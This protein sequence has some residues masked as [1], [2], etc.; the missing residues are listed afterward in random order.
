LSTPET[1]P[2]TRI[3]AGSRV[4][5]VA[6]LDNGRAAKRLAELG[7]TPETTIRVLQS[8][9]RH[10]MMISVRGCQMALDRYTARHLQ[11]RLVAGGLRHGPGRGRYGRRFFNRFR[12]GFGKRRCAE[13][14]LEENEAGKPTPENS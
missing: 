9:P 12:R 8:E 7:L 5:L 10:P 6:F 1:F 4:V 2:L 13:E 11:V 3:K 14:S